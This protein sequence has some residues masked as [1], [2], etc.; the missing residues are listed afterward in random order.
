MLL[1]FVVLLMNISFESAR[2]IQKE[3]VLFDT[4]K[5]SFAYALI[6]ILKLSNQ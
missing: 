5:I 2:H 4:V 6:K 1:L 3:D